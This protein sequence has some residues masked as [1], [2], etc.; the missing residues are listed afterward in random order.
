[1]N[2]KL[3]D[4]VKLPLFMDG[5]D[6]CMWLSRSNI[7]DLLNAT[8]SADRHWIRASD[9]LAILREEGVAGVSSSE[10]LVDGKLG[11]TPVSQN[12][13]TPDCWKS[14]PSVG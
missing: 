6:G 8:A 12:V 14:G 1:M 11:E 9:V 3:T 10:L 5:S 2:L 13:E 7:E 4:L